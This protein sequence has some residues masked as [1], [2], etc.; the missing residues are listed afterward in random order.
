MAFVDFSVVLS[1]KKLAQAAME[2]GSDLDS[3]EEA[4]EVLE[5]HDDFDFYRCNRKKMLKKTLRR[6]RAP[7]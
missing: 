2:L 1:L 6:K 4:N 5:E 7:C 3:D